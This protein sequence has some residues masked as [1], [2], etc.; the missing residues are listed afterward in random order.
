MEA[1]LPLEVDPPEGWNSSEAPIPTISSNT[2]FSSN[3][4]TLSQSQTQKEVLKRLEADRADESEVSQLLT[5]GKLTELWER[6]KQFYTP[7]VMTEDFTLSY[8]PPEDEVEVDDILKLDSFEGSQVEKMEE[9]PWQKVLPK[10]K[11]LRSFLAWRW[12]KIGV[13]WDAEKGGVVGQLEGKLGSDDDEDS[14]SED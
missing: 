8:H 5:E 12:K 13:D 10:D 3:D 6:Q 2:T 9:A 14:G 4:Q 7:Y 1:I 11:E